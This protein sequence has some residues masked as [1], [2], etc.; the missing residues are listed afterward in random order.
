MVVGVI[1]GA[2][3]CFYGWIMPAKTL[4]GAEV[5]E[6]I[7]GF[8]WFLSVTEKERLKFYNPPGRTPEQFEHFLPYAMSLGV[9][10]QWAGQ[11]ADIY[12]AQPEWYEGSGAGV[13]NAVIFASVMSDMSS[14]LNSLPSIFFKRSSVV[15]AA[16]DFLAVVSAAAA[17][18][19]GRFMK[20]QLS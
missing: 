9:E 2:L 17:E 8:K 12:K 18:G 1:T 7:Q 20:I 6:H 13:F 11:F 4:F 10:K 15:S 3:V 19:A 5:K 16:A 14:N